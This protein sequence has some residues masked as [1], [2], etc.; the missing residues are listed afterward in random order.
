M[1]IPAGKSDSYTRILPMNPPLDREQKSKIMQINSKNEERL[2][3]ILFFFAL[4]S[5]IAT[6]PLVPYAIKLR[7]PS[8]F[9]FES[10]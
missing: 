2:Q 9:S 10:Q 4:A 5:S 6:S 3:R 1:K 8:Y 7:A